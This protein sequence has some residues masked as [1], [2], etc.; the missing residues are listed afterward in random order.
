MLQA[1]EQKFLCSYSGSGCPSGAHRGLQGNI[2]TA[3]YG[4]SHART[5]GC[6]LEKTP[7]WIRF[8]GRK[9]SPRVAHTASVCS[10][11]TIPHGRESILEQFLKRCSLWER[12]LLE[13]FLK[14]CIPW[15]SAHTGAEE[16]C[17]EEREVEMK[18]HEQPLLHILLHCSDNGKKYRAV[19]NEAVR[20]TLGRRQ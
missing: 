10:W 18:H 1:P 8:S 12:L 14:D 15:E 6:S 9:C 5:C 3:V 16:E 19:E 7:H 13:K 20:L 11:W 2:H 4:E 17:V